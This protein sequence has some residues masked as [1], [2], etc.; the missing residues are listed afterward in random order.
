M[1]VRLSL[2]DPSVKELARASCA[3]ERYYDALPKLQ[4]EVNWQKWSD[5]L[6]HAALMAGTDAVLNGE[7]NH[8][9][10]LEGQQSTTSE[11]NDNVRR[12]AI[13][14]SR[15]ES[16]LKAMRNASDV[17]LT[18][19]DGANAH[20]IYLN[21]ESQ[22][23]TSDNQKVQA[24]YEEELMLNNTE[25]ADSPR[26]IANSLQ[27]AFDQYNQFVAR[28]IEQRLPENF[29][30]MDF[31]MSLDSAYGDWRKA[32]LKEQNVL[33]LDQGSTLTF[34]ELVDLVIAEHAR[35]LQEQTR[36]TT[37]APS[38][39]LQ[40]LS[41]RNISQVDE[42]AQQDVHNPRDRVYVQDQE[43]SA[44][45][46]EFED[47]HFDD[48]S[49]EDSE[50]NDGSDFEAEDGI[51]DQISSGDQHHLSS[52]E[53]TGDDNP[54][55]RATFDTSWQNLVVA[56]HDKVQGQINTVNRALRKLG[57]SNRQRRK[58]GPILEDLSGEW[59]LYSKEYNPSNAGALLFECWDITPRRQ[60]RLHPTSKQY[61]GRLTIGPREQLKIIET[62]TFS[63]CPRITGLPTTVRFRQPG[64]K[65]QSGE[66]TFW[67]DGKMLAKVPASV[68][69]HAS[70]PEPF[71]NFASLQS[72]RSNDSSGASDSSESGSNGG[73][74]SNVEGKDD[75]SSDDENSSSDSGD[76]EERY[77]RV[78]RTERHTS[79]AIKTEEDENT[80]MAGHTE[81]ASTSVAIK[82]EESGS[83]DSDDE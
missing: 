62:T 61:K 14:R 16:L 31:L 30:K 70:G 17:D 79:V 38:T 23:H 49:L 6:Q 29:L 22:Y 46:Q 40:Q 45:H 44:Q 64:A 53:Q 75:Q 2:S 7:S 32:L 1:N 50:S 36:S 33:A 13:W 76:D 25:L 55:Y 5:A 8:P 60:K 28:N 41:K 27:R 35:L 54:G 10:S 82:A 51:E 48:S 83:S 11:W 59:L 68:L 66:M 9:Q 52:G 56:H 58:R 77:D 80:A 39:P 18:A 67:G 37:R 4:G 19:F 12:T 47:Q 78:I 81:E 42:P 71:F 74:G 20:Q 21:L 3:H 43:Y 63:P 26:D 65:L 24:L 73:E 72:E 57:D 34:N 69:D 15:N